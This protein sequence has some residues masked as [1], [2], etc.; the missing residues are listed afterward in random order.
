MIV[1]LRAVC[2]QSYAVF[3]LTTVV[4]KY[5]FI[6]VCDSFVTNC[7]SQVSSDGFVTVLVRSAVSVSVFCS[8]CHPIY[9]K[10]Y[11]MK[12]LMYC[13]VTINLKP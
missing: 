5:W 12:L 11:S 2:L 13:I 7:V 8:S 9:Y 10:T 6:Q 4:Q 3:F 1:L